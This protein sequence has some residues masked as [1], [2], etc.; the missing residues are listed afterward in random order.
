MT[1]ILFTSLM[2]AWSA[3]GQTFDNNISISLTAQAGGP[4]VFTPLPISGTGNFTVSLSPVNSWLNVSPLAGSGPSTLT[5]TADPTALAA[6]AVYSG[7][8]TVSY[9]NARLIDF[10]L[11]SS[12]MFCTG[13]ASGECDARPLPTSANLSRRV[14]E[15][16][17]RRCPPGQA[18]PHH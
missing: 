13:S 17:P 7:E 8:I 18:D 15:V 10:P 5:I 2:L 3:R 1:K 6:G 14:R 16:D 12:M 9:L 4:A 11:F